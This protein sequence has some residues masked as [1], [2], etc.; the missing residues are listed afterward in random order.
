MAPALAETDRR[1]P[2]G[3]TENGVSSPRGVV[4]HRG[5]TPTDESP[6][7]LGRCNPMNVIVFGASGFIGSHIA[8]QLAAAGHRVACVVRPGSDIRFLSQLPVSI[9]RCRFDDPHSIRQLVG[10]GDVVCNCIADT[11]DY[12]PAAVRRRTEI[13]L[14]SD[15]Y[16]AALG[17]GA[18]GFMQLS[19]VMVYGFDRPAEPIDENF[20]PRPRYRYSQIAWEREQ[21]LTQIF[22]PELP[23]LLLRPANALG[24]RDSSFLPP[25]LASHRRGIFPVID[26]GEWCF[27]CID[28][29]DIGRSAAHLMT[30][31]WRGIEVYLVT[32]YDLDWL[33]LKAELDAASG[34]R[35][36]LVNLPRRLMLG[37]G[38]LSESARYLG[39][40]ASLTRFSVEVLSNHTLFD[41]QKIRRMGFTPRYR[42]TD[43]LRDALA[44]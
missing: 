33:A 7:F 10:P 25:F 14:T 26:G 21:T 16:R 19:T 39:A 15:I 23:L 31:S 36:R 27:S 1:Y 2:A 20:S 40:R 38:A 9:S 11:R 32:G 8:E 5:S 6:E 35:A 17:A 24:A 44:P 34:R 18:S 41:D 28:A 30:R 29:R 12:A 37:L 43:S 13:T 3:G 42:L 22:R 4:S